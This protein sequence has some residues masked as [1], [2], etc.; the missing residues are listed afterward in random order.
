PP[1]SHGASSDSAFDELIIQADAT[2]V[3]VEGNE[4]ESHRRHLSLGGDHFPIELD[5]IAKANAVRS[6]PKR[7]LSG[8]D[9]LLIR[10]SDARFQ[11]PMAAGLKD[12]YDVQLARGFAGR[13][14][15]LQYMNR[16]FGPELSDA[17]PPTF[18]IRFVPDGDVTLHQIIHVVHRHPCG[19]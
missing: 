10:S 4:L 18:G 2:A 11:F 17:G 16:I 15:R 19:R 12:R 13:L 1:V 9:E 14:W 8:C 7:E 5:D 3:R 6:R